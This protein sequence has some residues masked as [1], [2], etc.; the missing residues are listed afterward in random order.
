[1]TPDSKP[2]YEFDANLKAE[3]ECSILCNVALWLP[4]NAND[5][6]TIEI[7]SPE[8]LEKLEG[9]M[10]KFISIESDIYQTAPQFVA[11]LTGAWFKKL[12][13][14]ITYRKLSRTRIKLLHADDLT[15]TEKTSNQNDGVDA[16][17]S[18]QFEISNLLYAQPKAY[19]LPDYLGNRKIEIRK[20]YSTHNG[21]GLNFSLERHY[22]GYQAISA[23]KETVHSRNV[24]S[25][26]SEKSIR[27]SDVRN[28]FEDIND[29]VL[30]LTFAA[31][32]QT[33]AIG[34]EYLTNNQYVRHYI[35]PIE[36]YRPK[37]EEV[38]EDALIPLEHFEK[39]MGSALGKWHS[40]DK[41]VKLAIK[42]IIYSIHPFNST[43]QSYLDMFSAFEG[44]VAL[45]KTKVRSELD[46]NWVEIE[47]TLT[48]S[49]N[50]LV[51]SSEAKEFLVADIGKIKNREMF[52]KKAEAC[53]SELN[54][55]ID[56]LW[57]IFGGQASLY[58]IRNKLAHG[59]RMKLNSIYNIAQEHLQFLLERLVL[60]LLDFNYNLSTAG[61]EYHGIR[62]RHDKNEILRLQ[63]KL[64]KN[65]TSK[66]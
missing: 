39:F 23:N 56:D 21:S 15:I 41:K 55:E 17:T 37:H 65:S 44:I 54:I 52:G 6:V 31:R 33:K 47:D 8:K 59:N 10:G 53:L 16:I 26:T 3:N 51:I 62:F 25:V 13:G 48:K 5:D 1:M 2:N 36:R 14:Q 34:Y 61:S 28:I 66:E 22:S 42:D 38:V 12:E 32:H 49:I 20:Q 30:L 4:K 19:S 46:D 9:F 29:F 40:I 43:R 45:C 58:G 60:R 27:A 7:D 35:S 18:I 50:N 24:I 11:Q 63:Q 64:Y 57:P